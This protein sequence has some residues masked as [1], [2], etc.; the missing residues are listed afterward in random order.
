MK[1]SVKAAI[2]IIALVL[3]GG[4]ST[5]LSGLYIVP[6]HEQVIVTQFGKPIGDAITEPGLKWKVPFIQKANHFDKR[7]LEWDG[8]RNQVP[9]MDKKYIWIDTYA[10]WRIA[11][12]LQFFKRVRN[13]AGAQSRLD[14][15]LDGETRIAIANYELIEVVRSTNRKF[16]IPEDMTKLEEIV[17]DAPPIEHGR[18]EIMKG[19]LKN[20]REQAKEYGIELVDLRI[21]RLN[22]ISSVREKVYERMISERKRIAEK[23]R[24]EGHSESERILG[25]MEKELNRID[26]EAVRDSQKIRGKADA[27]ATKIYAEAYNRSPEFYAFWK[28]MDTYEKTMDKSSWLVLTTDGEFYKYMKKLE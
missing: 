20:A 7:W 12:P 26:S 24:S 22:Y 11:D 4:L 9:T 25:G 5:L 28:T 1:T 23:Y 21:K 19:I 10:R 18:L 17:V 14:D 15:I 2:V 13:E 3:I 8:E 16:E 27:K 6:M